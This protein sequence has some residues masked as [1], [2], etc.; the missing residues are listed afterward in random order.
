MSTAFASARGP[1]KANGFTLIEVLVVIA[2]IGIL[3][4]VAVP[5]FTRMIAEQRV[6]SMASDI[7]GDLVSA[8]IEA[9]KQQ[10]RVV[11]QRTG[12]TWKEGWQIFVDNNADGLLSAG[13]PVIKTFN[14]FGVSTSTVTP[15]TADF[16]TAIVFRGDGTVL[17]VPIG[18]ETGLLIADGDARSRNVVLSPAGRAT[19]EILP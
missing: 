12:A 17:N 3:A 16:A 18:A 11:M 6:R 1:A 10:R 2:I 19:V 7:M 13:E 5:S 15:I 8:R 9:I 14:G 4:A